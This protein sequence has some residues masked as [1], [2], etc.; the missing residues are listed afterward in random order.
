MKTKYY[1]VKLITLFLTFTALA[2]TS[3]AYA[4]DV[5]MYDQPKADAKIVG[6]ADLS[7]GIIPIFTPKSGDWVKIADPRNGNVGWVKS[8]E[9]TNSGSFSFTQRIIN[10]NGKGP[11]TYQIIQYGKPPQNMSNEQVQNMVQKLQTQQ[12]M[13]KNPCKKPY[14]I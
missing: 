11:Q 7:T 8:S 1:L 3:M 10:N 9:L 12:V 5:T 13:R 14:K 4:K 2:F 6:A